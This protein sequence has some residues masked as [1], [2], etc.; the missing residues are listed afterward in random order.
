MWSKQYRI[1]QKVSGANQT[2]H[3]T[4]NL[5]Q[6]QQEW[7]Y[8]TAMIGLTAWQFVAVS[9]RYQWQWKGALLPIVHKETFALELGLQYSGVLY[10]HINVWQWW[11]AR[12]KAAVRAVKPHIALHSG[13]N[14]TRATRHT[15]A[16]HITT[17]INNHAEWETFKYCHVQV[18][19]YCH[20]PELARLPSINSLTQLSTV[21]IL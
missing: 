10:V 18:V 13:A 11:S 8:I 5:C 16:A 19:L 6:W 3:Q 15:M 7:V 1:A 4:N 9:I 14:T 17:M 21:T 20:L 2:L 12:Y